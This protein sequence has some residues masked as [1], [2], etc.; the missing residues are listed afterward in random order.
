MT[1]VNF[2]FLA[3]I[4]TTNANTMKEQTN[5]HTVLSILFVQFNRSM[6]EFLKNN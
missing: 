3:H 1:D 2:I 5:K 6:Q 4:F